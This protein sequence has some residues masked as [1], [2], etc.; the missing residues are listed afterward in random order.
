MDTFNGPLENLCLLFPF[1]SASLK[2][3]VPKGKKGR[4]VGSLFL[5][6]NIIISLNY[7]LRL[8]LGHFRLFML[9]NQQANKGLL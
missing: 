1:G 6:E 9:L 8:P 3:L 7:E 5:S 2:V 4:E